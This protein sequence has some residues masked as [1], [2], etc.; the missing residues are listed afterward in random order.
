MKNKI[1][2]K[3]LIAFL[4]VIPILPELQPVIKEVYAAQPVLH[5]KT[6]TTEILH[7]NPDGLG[8]KLTMNVVL[9]Q[10]IHDILVPNGTYIQRG[11][12]QLPM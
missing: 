10:T 12:P 11:Q 5:W 1:Y 4:T 3:F 8:L 6:F 2:F 9:D 7:R